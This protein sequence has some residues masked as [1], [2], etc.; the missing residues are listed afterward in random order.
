[1]QRTI[2]AD[3]YPESARDG[4]THQENRIELRV[5]KAP[6]W[7]YLAHDSQ[8]TRCVQCTHRILHETMLRH[9]I[10]DLS[11]VIH[12]SEEAIRRLERLIDFSE[13]QVAKE[14]QEADLRCREYRDQLLEFQLRVAQHEREAG[15]LRII[16]GKQSNPEGS[17]LAFSPACSIESEL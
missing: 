8:T 12:N 1:M 7:I 9:Q 3:R 6:I 2:S 15:A 14:R 5:N 16:Q 11:D 17:Y 13:Q 10:S 4:T